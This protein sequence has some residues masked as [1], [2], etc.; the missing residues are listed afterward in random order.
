MTSYFNVRPSRA[1]KAR[2]LMTSRF[3]KKAFDGVS[4]SATVQ[5]C[6]V[7]VLLY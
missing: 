4:R 1:S 2:K 5:H 6:S 3:A 7:P